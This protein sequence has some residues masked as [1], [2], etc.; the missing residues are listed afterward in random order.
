MK[1]PSG[2]MV[3]DA[4]MLSSWLHKDYVKGFLKTQMNSIRELHIFLRLLYSPAIKNLADITHLYGESHASDS[5]TS[6]YVTTS[7]LSLP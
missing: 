1:T 5:S 3:L 7:S 2:D 6:F 4:D